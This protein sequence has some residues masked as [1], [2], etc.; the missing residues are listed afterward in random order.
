VA[1]RLGVDPAALAELKDGACYL[2]RERPGLGQELAEAVEAL[3]ARIVESP[4][5]FAISLEHAGNEV[6]LGLIKRF[7]YQITFVA[8]PRSVW[9]L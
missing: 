2:E 9:V 4:E 8:R 5:S 6:R 1:R 7:K 3:L